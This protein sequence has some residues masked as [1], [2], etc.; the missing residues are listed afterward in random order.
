[1]LFNLQVRT[2]VINALVTH[3]TIDVAQECED[4]DLSDFP[5]RMRE[6]LFSVMRD[7][8]DRQILSEHYKKL[9][10]EAEADA[11]QKWSNAVVWKWCDLDGHPKDK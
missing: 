6:W 11:T 2:L 4:E 1:M 7:M 10:E 8:A 9:E 5:R 3:I